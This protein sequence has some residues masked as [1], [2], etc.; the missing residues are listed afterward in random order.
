MIT[1]NSMTTLFGKSL[2]GLINLNAG[3]MIII[4]IV[5]LIGIGLISAVIG[6]VFL[7]KLLKKI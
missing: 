4:L 7:D 3:Q 2:M 5:E 6:N 1:Y